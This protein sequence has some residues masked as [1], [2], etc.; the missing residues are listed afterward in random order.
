[1][2]RFRLF[3]KAVRQTNFLILFC[4]LFGSSITYSQNS[5]SVL[6]RKLTFQVEDERLEDILLGLAEEGGF[7][8]S[9]NPDLM[10]VDS[11]ISLNVENSSVKTVLN[12]LLGKELELRISGNHLVILK[13]QYSSKS[14]ASTAESGSKK[15]T[16]DGT[17][18]LIVKTKF[19]EV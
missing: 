4:L 16:V 8:F 13:T 10:P 12:V 17:I 11:L 9:Y 7:S 3:P 2:I 1:M 14:L 15:Y 6:K 19:G 18:P 5:G